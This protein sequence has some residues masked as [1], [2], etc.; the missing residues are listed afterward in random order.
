MFESWREGICRQSF[1]NAAVARIESS[2]EGSKGAAI[3]YSARAWVKNRRWGGEGEGERER[4][5]CNRERGRRSLE[6]RE[7][8]THTHTHAHGYYYSD[9]IL[10]SPRPTKPRQ[11]QFQF[12]LFFLHLFSRFRLEVVSILTRVAPLP[13]YLPPP[14]FFSF[15]WE[16]CGP[17][18]GAWP[19]II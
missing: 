6:T 3:I 2:V 18:G 5:A 15:P 19:Q 9:R 8:N 13:P 1:R 12:S 10:I 4:E 14:R 11:A 7:I 17:S 16:L